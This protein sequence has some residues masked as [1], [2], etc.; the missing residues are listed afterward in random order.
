MDF[1]ASQFEARSEPLLRQDNVSAACADAGARVDVEGPSAERR[2][3]PPADGLPCQYSDNCIEKEKYTPPSRVGLTPNQKRTRHKMIMA[4]EWMVRKHGIERVGLLTLSF[5]V[6]GSGKGSYETWALRQQ[7]KE[8][9]F[10]QK[11]WHS[12]ST[13]IVAK[14]YEDWVCVFEMHRDRV[15][16]LHVVVATKEDIRTGTDMATLSNY[17]LP[18]RLRRGKHLRS[19]ALAAEWRVLRE[20]ACKYRFGRVE[21]LPVKKSGQAVGLYLGDYLVKTYNATQDGKRCRLVRFSKGINRAIGSKF[22]IHSLGNLIHRTRLKIAAGMLN[23]CDYGDF[24]DYFGPR[25][26]YYIKDSL[27]WIPMPFRF[28]KGA[29]ESGLAT[30][31]LGHYALNPAAYLDDRGKE[32][33]GDVSRAL[34]RRFDET[35]GESCGVAGQRSDND[36]GDDCDTADDLPDEAGDSNEPF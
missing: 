34:W 14:R 7:A 29:F 3:A 12:F 30:Q 8:W 11:R 26:N 20:T 36:C 35:L 22:S 15:W 23:F 1:V 9:D 5:G 25:W 6:P 4:V 21:L 2:A 24:A 33:L 28:L 18:F 19:E 16:H 27:A 32:K 10:V 13:N 17:K 31:L